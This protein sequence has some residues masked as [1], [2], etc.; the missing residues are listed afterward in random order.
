MLEFF[1]PTY[2]GSDT[3][4]LKFNVRKIKNQKYLINV[5]SK[6]NKCFLYC[7]TEFLYG[8][9]IINKFSHEE[10]EK[11]TGSFNIRDI[12]FPISIKHVKKFVKQ[13]EK[14][15]KFYIVFIVEMVMLDNDNKISTSV[16]IPFR[17]KTYTVSVIDKESIKKK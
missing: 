9:H 17:S 12:N 8:S 7:I 3:D 10:Y 6:D 16:S 11:Y 2:A 14:L 1:S 13:N 15:V 4:F 5:P